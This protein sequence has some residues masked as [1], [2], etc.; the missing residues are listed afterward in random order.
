MF[1]RTSLCLGLHAGACCVVITLALSFS[2]PPTPARADRFHIEASERISPTVIEGSSAH[3]GIQPDYVVTEDDP[4]VAI[5]LR[6]AARIGHSNQGY[7]QKVRA[8]RAL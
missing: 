5:V 8:V 6:A 1:D 4:D 3:G 2:A 7:W